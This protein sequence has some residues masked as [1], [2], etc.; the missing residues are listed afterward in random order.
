MNVILLNDNIKMREKHKHNFEKLFD[1]IIS[2]Q[3]KFDNKFHTIC[4]YVYTFK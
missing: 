4:G 2:R 3:K 1:I